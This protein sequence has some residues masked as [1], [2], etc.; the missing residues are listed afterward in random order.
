[1][2]ETTRR[3]HTRSGYEHDRK[4]H[5]AKIGRS[6]LNQAIIARGISPGKAMNLLQNEGIISDNCINIKDIDE[7]DIPKATEFLKQ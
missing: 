7:T 4:H 1:M 6:A 3:N 2:V 5:S